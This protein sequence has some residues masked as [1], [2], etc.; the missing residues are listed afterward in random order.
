MKR[1]A[2]EKEN[3]RQVQD[4]D[5]NRVNQSIAERLGKIVDQLGGNVAAGSLLGV[6][7]ATIRKWRNA[8]TEPRFSD[9]VRLAYQ[10]GHT[11]DWLFTGRSRSEY[12]LDL[13]LLREIMEAVE[14]VAPALPP[15]EKAETVLGFYRIYHGTGKSVET[16]ALSLIIPGSK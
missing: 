1:P 5:D 12:D 3:H 8:E 4:A 2:T 15:P 9:A 13:T 7:E 6:S 10:G 14:T 11:A 16:D